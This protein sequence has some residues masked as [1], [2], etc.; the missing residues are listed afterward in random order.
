MSPALGFFL[1]FLVTALARFVSG[2]L[3][4]KM[5]DVP[6]KHHEAPFALDQL[7]PRF[8]ESNFSKF[9]LFVA[10]VTFS[11]FIAAP[12]FSVFMLRDLQF[13]YLDYMLVNL[14]SVVAGLIGFPLWG[15]H[16]DHVG[17]GKILTLTS[18]LV[19][20]IPILWLFSTDLR[21]LIAVEVLS[22]FLWSGFSLCAV[23]FIFDSV[24]PEKR[25]RFISY[26]NLIIGIA[27]CAGAGIGGWLVDKLPAVLGHQFYALFILSAALRG[28]SHYFLSQK[29]TEIRGD[30]RKVKSYEL[31]LSVV[32]IK[33]ILSRG[34]GI[35]AI[36][37]GRPH[38]HDIPKD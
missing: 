31:F 2:H 5:E 33:S 38:A 19:P 9:V 34:H 27:I 3:M 29:F 37:V 36:P 17:N 1:L 25:V 20:I 7:W 11:T 10:A 6:L 28:L 24:A 18:L 16:A 15:K 30:A 35:S 21:W 22:G 14:A 4:S 23:N 32:G 13:S 12:Y 8:R 26:T